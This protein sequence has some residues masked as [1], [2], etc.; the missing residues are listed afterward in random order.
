[1]EHLQMSNGELDDVIQDVRQRYPHVQFPDVHLDSVFYGMQR[2]TSKL[3]KGRQAIV[4]TLDDDE[5][6]SGICSDQYMLIPHE[7]AVWKFEHILDTEEAFQ[8]LGRANIRPNLLGTNGVKMK[9]EA[10]FP[11]ANVTIAGDQ[12]NPK[13]GIKTSYDLS[14]QW[15]PWFGGFVKR[16]TNGL[17]MWGNLLEGGRKHKMSLDLEANIQRLIAG[18]EKLDE[19]F[20][21]WDSW[22]KK[23]ITQ[24]EAQTILVASPLSDKQ[25]ENIME[26]PEIGT[27][28]QLKTESDVTPWF[29]NSIVTQYIEHELDDTPARLNT[30]EKV[31]NYL[32]KAFEEVN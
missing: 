10:T 24:A 14:L 4:A 17:L 1:M 11:E 8:P 9:L 26:L 31:T 19:M 2:A 20:G 13:A 16:C 15:E 7:W 22:T 21:I 18:V 28:R 32:N 29:V 12:V 5:Y 30:E 6:L 27:N 3:A 25:V 23:L